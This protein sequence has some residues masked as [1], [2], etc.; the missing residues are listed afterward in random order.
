MF[1]LD[2]FAAIVV[3]LLIYIQLSCS[4]PL[5]AHF[6]KVIMMNW[7]WKTTDVSD[8][9]FRT[10]SAVI[11]LVP[12]GFALFYPKVGSVLGYAASLSGFLMIYVVPVLAYFK[13][14]KVEIMN[15]M[16]AA[17]LQENEVELYVPQSLPKN[18]EDETYLT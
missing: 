14:K 8:F 16:L 4:Y 3:R 9:T 12:M 11:T 5:V 10:L 2:D 13:M 6:L 1:A 15:P 17:A 18:I 7:I